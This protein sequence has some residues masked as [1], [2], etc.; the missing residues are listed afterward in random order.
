MGNKSVRKWKH[1]CLYLAGC[2]TICLV[3]GSCVAGLSWPQD[4]RLATSTAHHLS[5]GETMLLNGDYGAAHK[6]SCLLLEQFAGQADDQALYLLG[7]IWIHPDNPRQDL[8]LADSYYRRII[9]HYPESSLV[10][11]SRTWRAVIASMKEH[12]QIT[13][14]METTSLALRQQLKSEAN[15]RIQLEER[16]QQMKAIDLD[17]Q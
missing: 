11:A 15:R 6:E 9:V 17:L 16:L 3:L 1:L 4:R 14:K 10:A 13:E 12:R 2:L 8:R 5:R 7:M